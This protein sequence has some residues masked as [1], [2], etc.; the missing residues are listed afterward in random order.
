MKGGRG[1]GSG[2]QA[3]SPPPPPPQLCARFAGNREAGQPRGTRGIGAARAPPAWRWRFPT[4]NGPSPFLGQGPSPAQLLGS[5]RHWAALGK[6]PTSRPLSL[7][8]LALAGPHAGG[9]GRGALALP[10]SDLRAPRSAAALLAGTTRSPSRG[11]GGLPPPA[12]QGVYSRIDPRAASG[13]FL[14]TGRADRG[15]TD[16]HV[17]STVPR[18]SRGGSQRAAPGHCPAA[19][20][21]RSPPSSSRSL[22]EERA[23]RASPAPRTRPEDERGSP[24]P[25]PARSG[26]CPQPGGQERTRSRGA[27]PL[28]RPTRG[29]R[30]IGALSRPG[31]AGG[32]GSS[33][34][35]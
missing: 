17:P 3:S 33:G 2:W 7:R 20:R 23:G 16:G 12:C 27:S 13:P 19:R 18:G 32:G 8:V 26:V 15:R 10:H 5:K 30:L 1:S 29:R 28:V 6:V 35:G 14:R 4:P 22:R 9:G 25:A 21:L 31:R 11:G 24:V 34:V